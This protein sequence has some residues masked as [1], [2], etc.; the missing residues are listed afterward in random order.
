MPIAQ[1]KNYYNTYLVPGEYIRSTH[2]DYDT[3]STGVGGR[4]RVAGL[5]RILEATN[6]EVT[7]TIN[8]L[9]QPYKSDPNSYHRFNLKIDNPAHK[10]TINVLDVVI[11]IGMILDE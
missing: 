6:G 9:T 5:N 1:H 10:L 11:L 4:S 8:G 2:S 3:S 7:A